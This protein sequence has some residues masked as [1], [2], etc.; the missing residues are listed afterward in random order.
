MDKQIQTVS[1]NFN[2]LKQS[3]ISPPKYP[4]YLGYIKKYQYT[5]DN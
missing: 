4:I 3:N 2:I 1:A 5:F